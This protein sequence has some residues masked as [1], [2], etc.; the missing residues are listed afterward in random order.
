MIDFT[1][2][3]LTYNFVRSDDIDIDSFINE[4]SLNYIFENY[5][6]YKFSENV[7]GGYVKNFY[8]VKEDK[9]DELFSDGNLGVKLKI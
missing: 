8:G 1:S 7:G 2:S 3:N 6:F 9:I 4:T 5:L